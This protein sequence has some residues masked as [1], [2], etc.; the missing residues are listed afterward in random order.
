MLRF[1][2]NGFRAN[3]HDAIAVIPPDP[4]TLSF[5]ERAKMAA[6]DFIDDVNKGYSNIWVRRQ[7]LSIRD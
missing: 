3:S 7:I 6:D 4:E 5:S 2:R 1:A